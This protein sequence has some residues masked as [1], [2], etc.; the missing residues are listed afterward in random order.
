[1]AKVTNPIESMTP[2]QILTDTS[3][4]EFIKAM[5]ISIADAQKALDVNSLLML[6][7]YVA[8]HTR[9]AGPDGQPKSLMEL[10]LLP[11]FYHYQYADLTVSL[12]LTMKVGN[13]ES[14]G[15]SGRL[16]LGFATGSPGSANARTAQ[17]KLKSQPASVTENGRRID[18]TGA[19]LEAAG[20]TLATAL[21]TPT[22]K[23]AQVLVSSTRAEVQAVFEPSSILEGARN[24]LLTPG[25]I[26]FLPTGASSVGVI[27]ISTL[28]TPQTTPESYTLTSGTTI[29]VASATSKL[30]YARNVRN[31]IEALDGFTARLAHDPG[32]NSI[33]SDAAE[34]TL[35]IALFA[36]GSSQIRNTANSELERAARLIM[37]S[38][39]P[40]NVAGYTDL[41]GEGRFD[42]RKLRQERAKAVK[43]QL[44]AF[45]V[46]ANKITENEGG[47]RW[48]GTSGPADNPQFRRAEV[49]LVGSTDLFIVVEGVGTEQ[50]QA[51]PLPD[52][53][54]NPVGNGFIVV[55]QITARAV[56]GTAVSVGAI[57]TSVPIS[58]TV[59]IPAEETLIADSPETFAF[60]LAK[61]INA[62]STTSR[63]RASRRG[64]VVLLA[65]V[66]DAVTLDMVAVS[67]VEIT[68]AADGG[69]EV[70][71]PLA[72]LTPAGPT[73]SSD[74]SNFT[75]AVG[76]TVDY[77]TSR[78]FE[79]SVTGNS[80]I[81]ARL[82]AV[83]APIEFLEEIK[84]YL[85]PE[86]PAITPIATPT[87]APTP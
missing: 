32:D 86:T 54:T 67:N 48:A 70:T 1:M 58:G 87:P 60:N 6:T 4:S 66:D 5:G 9:L 22:G 43:T 15:I 85:T 78:Q 51:T 42:N 44:I 29:T 69:A 83:P 62:G 59:P 65:S 27:R 30:G 40:V 47:E 35:F 19:D 17:L 21:R 20:E 45:G 79:Q 14:F 74:S 8:L 75:V 81:S 24:P 52:R 80:T 76:A 37:A 3:V 49:T 53:R 68:L 18:A 39:L 25:A 57:P 11:P 38:G 26:A 36:V 71:K 63:V 23:F 12:Q 2:G 46:H 56:T 72:A 50:L 16:D 64:S 55:H 13:S 41:Q 73:A 82:V 10:G 84:K 33:A 31:A 77:R 28:P 34:G 61:A 7:E